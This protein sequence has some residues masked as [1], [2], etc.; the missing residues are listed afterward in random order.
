MYKQQISSRSHEKE[1]S[2]DLFIDFLNKEKQKGA[3]HF[4]VKWSGDPVWSFQW[5][6]TFRI[7]SKD[8]VKEIEIQR[9]QKEIDKLKK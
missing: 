4:E 6:N 5:L 7:K 1:Y 9:L 2:I 3:T 8:E